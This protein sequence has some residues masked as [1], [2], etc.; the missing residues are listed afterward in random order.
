MVACTC[1]REA[2]V[3]QQGCSRSELDTSVSLYL[4][5]CSRQRR[6]CCRADKARKS[7]AT[8]GQL[9]ASVSEH[10]AAH[11]TRKSAFGQPLAGG[12]WHT[13]WVEPVERRC[14]KRARSA[15]QPPPTA[16]TFLL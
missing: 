2:L 10:A 11:K 6:D 15:S 4:R 5:R 12:L 8:R 9:K 13:E 7:K 1:S 3:V 16:A 14:G